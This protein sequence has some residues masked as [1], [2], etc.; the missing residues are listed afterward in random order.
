MPL[1]LDHI[2]LAVPDL[3]AA[4]LDY[5]AAG[6][7]ASFGGVHAS[8]TT[9]NGLVVF[10]DG[11][12]LELMALTGQ[13]LDPA[14]SAAD[15]SHLVRGRQGVAGIALGTTDD[16]SKL[17]DELRG[18]GVR[19]KD[20]VSGSRL[21]GDGVRLAWRIANL[22]EHESPFFL[23]DVTDRRLR[24]PDSATMTTHANGTSGIAGLRFMVADAS[25]A[26]AFYR[27][28]LDVEPLIEGDNY[29]FDVSGVDLAFGPANSTTPG[30]T[31]ILKGREE[32]L[33][34]LIGAAIQL[35]TAS[36]G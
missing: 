34:H 3:D 1:F 14:N 23:E 5:Q 28:L 33:L 7:N 30:V 6:F 35:T 26:A 8:G 18:R 16:L 29:H 32:K 36:A 22:Q 9:H 13:A 15:Y 27:D 19:V 20:P 17:V 21:R 31:V 11:T 10:A 2:I 4:L 25:Q 24:V 12:Y